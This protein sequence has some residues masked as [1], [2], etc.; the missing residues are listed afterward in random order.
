[1]YFQINSGELP[2]TFLL[3]FREITHIVLPWS[4]RGMYSNAGIGAT[5]QR[6]NNKCYLPL[7]VIEVSDILT[8][9]FTLACNT[10]DFGLVAAGFQVSS[11]LTFCVPSES[12]QRD[13][14][15]YE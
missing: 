1:M 15:K 7:T 9:M 12:D 13:R 6:Y 10:S 8:P 3:P 4:P 14:S 2:C 11:V 5:H